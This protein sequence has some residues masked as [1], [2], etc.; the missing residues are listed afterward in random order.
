MGVQGWFSANYA[1]SR[2]KFLGAAGNAGAAIQSYRNPARG[3]DGG[4]LFTDAAWLGPEDAKDV[5]LTCSGTHGVEGFCGAGIQI[6]SFRQRLYADLPRGVALLA[7]HAINPYGFAW[8]RRVT[9]D[10]VD[11]NRNFVDYAQPMRNAPYDEI[12]GMLVPDDWEGPNHAKANQ[13]IQNFIQQRGMSAY[14]AA[15]TGG[16]YDHADGLFYGGR[17]PTWSHRTV[18]EIAQKFLRGR[19]RVAF[20]DYHTGL[21]PSGFGEIICT[22]LPNTPGERR[23][24]EWYG[25][26]KSPW[27]GSSASAPIEGFIAK[28]LERELP[29]VEL[30][31]IAIEYGTFPP[32]VV[33]DSLRGDNW[34]HLKGNP[35]SEQGRK[36]KAEIRRAF[37]PD[38]DVWKEQVWTRAE[39]VSRMALARLKS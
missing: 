17:K 1:E 3:P 39:D 6:A 21:G 33:L 20:I 38:T 36:I 22:H 8:V 9:E 29:D 13:G 34:L 10:N 35:A 4:A 31:S 2:E 25:E 32:G 7:V 18:L 24:K 11:L 28:G 12:H 26:A 27:D 5:L 30:T 14:Q 37:Y 23:C 16:Q 19:R 15:L